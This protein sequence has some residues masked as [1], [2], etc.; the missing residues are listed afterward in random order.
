MLRVHAK[1]A[2]SDVTAVTAVQSAAILSRAR[3]TV[4]LYST[5]TPWTARLRRTLAGYETVDERS[6]DTNYTEF[7]F[8]AN[9]WVVE[10]E[11]S[12]A[13]NVAVELL[14]DIPV[15]NITEVLTNLKIRIV[16][17]GEVINLDDPTRVLL[18]YRGDHVAVR[19]ED[20]ID[21]DYGDLEL[22]LRPDVSIYDG[23]LPLVIEVLSVRHGY[24]H[25]L[26]FGEPDYGTLLATTTPTMTPRLVKRMGIDPVSGRII[27]EEVPK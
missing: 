1:G 17:T 4:A 18:E 27:W 5:V 11:L 10:A 20:W 6:L 12:T 8:E 23:I 2:Y 22:R 24:S 15:S 25:E 19:V 9:D 14:A 16:D 3:V 21:Y 13:G 7:S 26:W